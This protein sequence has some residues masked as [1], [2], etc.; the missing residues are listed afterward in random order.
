MLGDGRVAL[1]PADCAVATRCVLH[2]Y[3]H[4][5]AGDPGF[6]AF[7][8]L[9]DSFHEA[10][11]QS[12]PLALTTDMQM[13]PWAHGGLTAGL[14][15]D[16]PV[17]PPAVRHHDARCTIADMVRRDFAL[18]SQPQAL[19]DVPCI[20][21]PLAGDALAVLVAVYMSDGVG[22]CLA[23]SHAV[24]DIGGATRFCHEWCALARSM[25][26]AAGTHHQP[27][28]LCSDRAW[29]WG[30]VSAR[31]APVDSAFY[32][33]LYA[34]TAAQ[35]PPK[36]GTA[37]APLY[38]IA[39]AAEA[40]GA[41]G[42]VRARACPG[43]SIPNFISA[44]I[45]RAILRARPDAEH[46]YFAASLTVRTIE[47]A[48]ADYWGNTATMRYIHREAPALR[49]AAIGEIAE[50]VQGCTS[51]FSVAEYADILERYTSTPEYL[52]RLEQFV[53]E[54]RAPLLMV[55]NISR[56][57]VYAA[58]FGFGPPAKVC[59]P[60]FLPPGFAVFLPRSAAGGIDILIHASDAAIRLLASDDLVRDHIAV[61][62][63][64]P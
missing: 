17:F 41:L 61:T 56:L 10:L 63:Y 42:D 21:N 12:L 26:A 54:G 46:A 9:R 19:L 2:Y 1:C 23:L 25:Y 22:V 3:F 49:A 44:V 32:R 64:S 40:L 15:A 27:Q 57:P 33:H 47:P 34:R 6:M 48:F 20:A 45:W 18:D 7:E 38:R 53:E 37:G 13:T 14:S 50:A 52:A 51:G 24:V 11:H 31:R 5:A 35:Q 59:Y 58:D 62:A 29:F 60:P 8:V 43:A 16:H 30:A 39:I 4:N 28:R 36:S 55:A